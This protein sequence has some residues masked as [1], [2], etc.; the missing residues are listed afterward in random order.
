MTA[1]QNHEV[2]R[3]TF[4]KGIGATAAAGAGLASM[5]PASASTVPQRTLGPGLEA[6]SAWLGD[7]LSGL[8]SD[9]DVTSYTG[10]EAQWLGA[11]AAMLSL[12]SQNEQVL[13]SLENTKDF[14]PNAALPQAMSAGISAFNDG[15]DTAEAQQIAEDEIDE[16]IS[17][18]QE[19][20]ATGYESAIHQ[21][22]DMA[23]VIY[24]FEAADGDDDLI[25]VTGGPH[26][27]FRMEAANFSTSTGQIVNS[28]GSVDTDTTNT[29]NL[30]NGD[31]LEIDLDTDSNN[32][33]DL[34]NPTLPVVANLEWIEDNDSE[35]TDRELA[36]D[37]DDW[38]GYIDELIRD[39]F[40]DEVVPDG[41]FDDD[42]YEEEIEDV[43]EFLESKEAA[44]MPV[45]VH[46]YKVLW[47]DLLTIRNDL[48]D[49]IADFMSDFGA[50]YDEGDVDLSDAVD[51]I[52]AYTELRDSGDADAYSGAAAGM[53]GIPS[54]GTDPLEIELMESEV[55]VQGGI[56]SSDQPEG[57]FS[58]GEEYDPENK[59]Y[60]IF[61]RYSDEFEDEDGEIVEES[62]FIQIEEPF[63]I[64]EA[65]DEDGE[66][67]ESVEMEEGPTYDP[68][69]VESIE[70]QLAQVRETQIEIQERAAEQQSS[71]IGFGFLDGDSNLGLLA[72]VGLAGLVA[73]EVLTN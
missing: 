21:A 50:A 19:D 32:L 27:F 53:L 65:L 66:E 71:G 18:V 22:A 8:F 26:V 57:G 25:N 39:E 30:S 59:E 63:T 23:N 46:R 38:H 45:Q 7:S 62:G 2:G 52:T 60:P 42:V 9:D 1:T 4:V 12:R 51:P 36:D 10:S 11:E 13:S 56:Y 61:L 31:T 16:Y 54:S 24:E 47:D 41:D 20:I 34:E 35:V 28:R 64:L 55:I 49:E 6:V 44:I 73:W 48:R 70:E 67:R 5:S 40:G 69:D 15:E 43:I 37:A 33:D 29:L 72:I 58:V 14:A 17:M 3:R 68:A